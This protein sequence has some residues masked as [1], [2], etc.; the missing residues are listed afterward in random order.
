M[1][2][3]ERSKPLRVNPNRSWLTLV[4]VDIPRVLADHAVGPRKR[5]A[6]ESCGKCAAA[7]G[8]GRSR[9]RIVAKVRIASKDLMPLAEVAIEPR[10]ELV[11][12]GCVTAD[13]PVVV[14]GRFVAA[15]K[16]IRSRIAVEHGPGRRIDTRRGN[17]VARKRVANVT[18]ARLPRRPRIEDRL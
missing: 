15:R 7:V 1:A 18:G 12:C 8:Q 13:A 2:R 9:L 4:G 11:L 5:L 16:Y 14:R 10:I 6:D 17:H 3:E